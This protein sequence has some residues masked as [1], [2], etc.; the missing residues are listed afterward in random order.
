M[1]KTEIKLDKRIKLHQIEI[2]LKIS[3][4]EEYLWLGV[5]QQTND[6]YYVVPSLFFSDRDFLPQLEIDI[7]NIK[8][9]YSYDLV[10]YIYEILKILDKLKSGKG[11]M[12]KEVTMSNEKDY[13]DYKRFKKLGKKKFTAMKELIAAINA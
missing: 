12:T 1:S 2:N 6:M 5:I 10:L 9:E 8:E 4:G 7:K 3:F 13:N 11:K